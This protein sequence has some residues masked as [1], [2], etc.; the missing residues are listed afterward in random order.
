MVKL[1]KHVL[2]KTYIEACKTHRR[3]FTCRSATTSGK[4]SN[5]DQHLLTFIKFWTSDALIQKQESRA[6]LIPSLPFPSVISTSYCVNKSFSTNLVD[7][8]INDGS[9][10][11]SKSFS[12]LYSTSHKTYQTINLLEFTAISVF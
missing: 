12:Y 4:F 3:V 8:P 11:A 1:G 2:L 6:A 7:Q 5:A 10:P 9:L